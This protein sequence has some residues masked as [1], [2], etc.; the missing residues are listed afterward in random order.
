MSRPPPKSVRPHPRLGDPR[1]G[2]SSEHAL[3]AQRFFDRVLRHTRGRG[4]GKPFKLHSSQRWRVIAPLYGWREYDDL[5]GWIRAYSELFLE[6]PRG[7]G[8]TEI[9][10]GIGLYELVTQPAAPEVY[11]A[12]RTAEQA[13]IAWSAAAAMVQASHELSALLRVLPSRRRI[14][15]PQTGG[16][17]RV[18]AAEAL[19]QLGGAPAAVI[20]DEFQA[21]RD[22][23]LYNALRQGGGKRPDMLVVL[24]G[25]AGAAP[26]SW[27]HTQHELSA[28]IAQDPDLD[29]TRLVVID[30][31]PVDA[32][33]TKPA[34]WRKA[35]PALRGKWLS[36]RTLAIECARAQLNPAEEWSFRTYRLNQWLRPEH[37]WTRLALW[38]ACPSEPVT[39]DDLAGRQVW[40]G[41]DLAATHDLAALAWIADGDDGT[42]L[43]LWRVWITDTAD[44]Q[45]DAETS[46]AWRQWADA[47]GVVVCPSTI[48]HDDIA[49]AALADAARLDVADVGVDRFDG[50][51]VL[52]RFSDHG[53]AATSLNQGAYLSP[54][55]KALADVVANQQLRHG[56]NPVA[57]WSAVN[58][59]ARHDANERVSLVRPPREGAA[60]RIDPLAALVM[61]VDRRMAPVEAEPEP[62]PAIFPEDL[63]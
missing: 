10:S 28:R 25:T 37:S 60:A 36:E 41:I 9:A 62:A 20:L 19:S 5:D 21:Q 15:A 1:I 49:D 58:A 46:G 52:T 55:V 17:M 13:A 35:N 57:A 51:H 2:W 63:L 14:I 61:A 3:H 33:W 11:L 44:T 24:L 50:A 6:M 4:A 26:G 32:D 18:I 31:A 45:L 54:A 16:W 43:V 53:L 7:N 23:A 40:G 27:G 42:L 59:V 29:P 12:A 34:T 47:A 39:L 30:T 56:G 22:G 48:S 8:K 38:D